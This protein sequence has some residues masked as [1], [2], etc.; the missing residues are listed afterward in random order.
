[1]VGPDER[2]S[3]NGTNTRTTPRNNASVR[4]LTQLIN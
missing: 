4:T 3:P 2:M 1:V